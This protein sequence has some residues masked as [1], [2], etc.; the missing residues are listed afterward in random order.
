MNNQHLSNIKKR[1]G[2]LIRKEIHKNSLK[3]LYIWISITSALLLLFFALEFLFRFNTEIRVVLFF[4]ILGFT[5]FTFL[6]TA[7]RPLLKLLKSF[8]KKDIFEASREVGETYPELKDDLLNA[9]QLVDGDE[10]GKSP[11]SQSLINAAFE[12]VF[13]KA[14]SMDFSKAINFSDIQHLFI[15]A[16]VTVFLLIVVVFASPDFRFSALRIM[17]YDLKYIQPQKFSFEVQPGDAS[18]LKGNDIQIVVEILGEKPSSIGFYK[19]SKNDAE[20]QIEEILTDSASQFVFNENEIREEFT[21]YFSSENIE[22]N[23]YEI[24][25]LAPPI[26]EDFSLKIIPPSYANLPPTILKNNGAVTSLKGS[27]IE[28]DLR[29]S[30]ILDSAAI[31]F[32]D[33]KIKEMKI[34]AKLAKTEFYIS[35]NTDYFFSIVDTAGIRNNKPIKY[36]I[37]TILDEYP[38]IEVIK[39]NKDVRISK[40]FVLPIELE[41]SD[42]YG[43]SELLLKYK[44]TATQFGVIKENFE[45]VKIPYENG[46]KESE[47]YY[48]WDLSEL[49]LAAGDVV[50]YYFEVFDNDN[51]SGPKSSRTKIFTVKVPSMDEL[52]AQSDETQ[53][54]AVDELSE[55]L[56]EAK[57]LQDEFQNISNELK[58]DQQEVTFEE[59]EKI[60][61]TLDKFEKLQEKIDDIQKSLNDM[62]KEMNENEL[63]SEETMQ[64]YMELQELMDEVNNEE[65]QK[66]FERMQ[67]ML[68]KF[69]RNQVQKN[70]ENV[71]IDEE[72]FQ[73]SIER[74]LNLLKRMQV[75]QRIDELAKRAEQLQQQQEQLN[76]QL[77]NS[78]PNDQKAQDELSKKQDEISKQ[79][80]KMKERMEELAE[81]MSELS[82][83]PME[84]MMKMMEEFANQNN[85]ELSEQA[86]QQISEMQ[87]SEASETQKQLM[88]NMKNM[89]QQISQMQQSMQQKNQ[90]EVFQDLMR[91]IDDVLTLSKEQERLKGITESTDINTKK[92]G[93]TAQEQ[94]ELLNNISKILSKMSALS[95]KTFAITPEMGKALGDARREMAQAVNSMQERNKTAS[96][97]NQ[98]DAMKSLNQA[99]QFMQGMMAQMMNSNGQ[100]SGGMM[101]LMQQLQQMSQQQM[102]LNQMTQMMQ[103]GQLS[104]QQM[105]QIQR[106]AQEQELIQK[107]LEQLNK[108]AEESGQSKKLAADLKKA[109]QEMK[110]VVQNMRSNNLDDDVLQKQERILSRLLDAQRS[111]NDRDFEKDRESKTARNFD[112]NSPPEVI[113]SSEEGKN[114]LREELIKAIREGYKKDY[115]DLIRKY[116]EALETEATEN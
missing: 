35:R 104:Q 38:L 112:L 27:K 47:V 15:T 111:M 92:F 17:N 77:Q 53:E 87:K 114:I 70:F 68:E 50:S 94:S 52:F 41:I 106:L 86:K 108:E 48:T 62:M 63:L 9:I 20:F 71:K 100:G 66:S 90:M 96:K 88:Q 60:K 10:S 1:L 4:A 11:K 34:E 74:T 44:L 99:A 56:K 30:K 42:D 84:D 37:N 109:L 39:P 6:A 46:S 57:K 75:E 22:S 43:F 67:E 115:E 58:K 91:I 76:E 110:E 89:Q 21:Y 40:Q 12:R 103:S 23:R 3:G 59:K 28:F 73:K 79:I 45:G 19:K 31:V 33:K 54:Q 82:D 69:Q 13:K 64:K 65:M 93:E 49:Y 55:I 107:S 8:S 113:L 26:I 105:Q 61:N 80:E 25:V 101:S 83:M 29:S 5:L 7:G 95:N 36:A 2:G 98:Q 102:S 97:Q 16:S 24:S 14:E 81:N 32:G 85:E 116:F 51:V 72:Q 78:D 18:V